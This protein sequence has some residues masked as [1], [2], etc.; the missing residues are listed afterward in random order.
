MKFFRLV[1]FT[2]SVP[3]WMP[4]WPIWL[5]PNRLYGMVSAY[6][7]RFRYPRQFS[8]HTTSLYYMCF[9]VCL[10]IQSSISIVKK[11][12][13][14]SLF[15]DTLIVLLPIQIISEVFRTVHQL[16]GEVSLSWQY[17]KAYVI[18]IIS[19]CFICYSI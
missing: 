13:S 2:I 1:Y 17:I 15:S 7:E 18:D 19:D 14:S 8:L 9:S 12:N 4:V 10:P 11:L 5:Y 3:V 6:L 16:V